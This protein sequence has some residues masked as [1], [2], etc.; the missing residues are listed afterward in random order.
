MR[1]AAGLAE[2]SALRV[3][4]GRVGKYGP[5]GLR[6]MDAEVAFPGMKYFGPGPTDRLGDPMVHRKR[7]ER[8]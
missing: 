8:S 3:G 1:G 6:P 5:A 7:Q 4:V 2:Q